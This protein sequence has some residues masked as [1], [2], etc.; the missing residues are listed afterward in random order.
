MGREG[1]FCYLGRTS[2][3]VICGEITAGGFNE[4]GEI[5]AERDERER[6]RN[7]LIRSDTRR[8][9]LYA[10]FRVPPRKPWRGHN[11]PYIVTH[12]AFTHGPQF[13]VSREERTRVCLEASSFFIARIKRGVRSTYGMI[14]KVRA[15]PRAETLEGPRRG[16][17]RREEGLRGGGTQRKCGK[18]QFCRITRASQLMLIPRIGYRERERSTVS[19][20]K[21]KSGKRNAF[22][23]PA[24]NFLTCFV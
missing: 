12:R 13:R 10:D 2:A 19:E 7:N 24:A 9:F 6:G 5:P 22:A 18:L 16:A 11:A 20:R 14:S 21:A 8:A 17:R 23:F 1:Y 3:F 15:R 4:R